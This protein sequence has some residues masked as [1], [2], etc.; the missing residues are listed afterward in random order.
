MKACVHAQK[1]LVAQSK[2]H[3]KQSWPVVPKRRLLLGP[4]TD[5]IRQPVYIMLYLGGV[6]VSD[7]RL[8]FV[9]RLSDIN[10]KTES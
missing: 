9:K 2:N 5:L 1:G 3:Q 4:T 8:H 7:S 10:S 6:T